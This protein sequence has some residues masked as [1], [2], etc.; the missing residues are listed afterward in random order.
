MRLAAQ[1]PCRWRPLS[2]NVRA[3]ANPLVLSWRFGS[4]A[5]PLGL[6]QSY[7]VQ[8]PKH[9]AARKA[10]AL[11]GHRKQAARKACASAVHERATLVGRRYKTHSGGCTSQAG[12]GR[13]SVGRRR[14]VV[15]RGRVF[16]RLA[17]MLARSSQGVRFGFAQ[18]RRACSQEPSSRSAS[19]S[20]L[21]APSGR[22]RPNPSLERTLSGM[23]P[24]P[25]SAV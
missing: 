6:P 9:H 4:A 1:A 13:P 7:F 16:G 21:R 3:H 15:C 20:P 23:P 19:S 18:H 24:R 5:L 25:P 2:S 8:L 10:C 22:V 14:T 12:A 11:R 17:A